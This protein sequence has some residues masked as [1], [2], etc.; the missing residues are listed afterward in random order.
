MSEDHI[1]YVTDDAPAAKPTGTPKAR[2]LAAAASLSAAQVCV[3]TGEDHFPEYSYRLK[4]GQRPEQRFPNRAKAAAYI[5]M[6]AGL[7]GP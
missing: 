7:L 6:A 5:E 1:E 3:V 4:I 2:I